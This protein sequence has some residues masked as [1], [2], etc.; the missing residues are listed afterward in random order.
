MFFKLA[1]LNIDTGMHAL[2]EERNSPD[3]TPLMRNTLGSELYTPGSGARHAG[4]GAPGDDPDF[5]PSW[6]KPAK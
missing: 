3:R 4:F 1:G 2:R 6:A 5:S